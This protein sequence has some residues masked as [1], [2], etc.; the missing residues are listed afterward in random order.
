MAQAYTYALC[1]LLTSQWIKA[2][3]ERQIFN[4]F[5]RCARQKHLSRHEEATLEMILGACH[6]QILFA[7]L[8]FFTVAQMRFAKGGGATRAFVIKLLSKAYRNVL[9]SQSLSHI[10]YRTLNFTVVKLALRKA[11]GSNYALIFI[12]LC[13]VILKY[14]LFNLR[15]TNKI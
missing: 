11:F 9:H 2:S 13:I 8:N 6:P 12:V 3:A 14:N 7:F 5:D 1:R 4:A 10:T 15:K